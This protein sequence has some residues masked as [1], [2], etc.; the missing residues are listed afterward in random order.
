LFGM[1]GDFDFWFDIVTPAAKSE[2]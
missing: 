1:L 2:G